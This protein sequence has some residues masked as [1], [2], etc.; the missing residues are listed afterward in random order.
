MVESR[1]GS[2][3]AW[4]LEQDGFVSALKPESRPDVGD[5]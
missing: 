5:H 2:L 4:A 1:R 3:E